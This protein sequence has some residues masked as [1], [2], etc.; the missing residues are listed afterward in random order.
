[1]TYVPPDASRRLRR[2]YH[3]AERL[4]HAAAERW[5]LPCEPLLERTG[6]SRR[7]RGLSLPER[8]RNVGGAFRARAAAGSVVLVDDVYTTGATASEA[9]FALRTGGARR[10]DVVTFARAVRSP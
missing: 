9:A 1:V 10:V 4:A 2:G 3:P 7:Q 8:R 5:D 6:R